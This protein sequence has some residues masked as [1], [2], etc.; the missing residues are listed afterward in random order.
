[1]SREIRFRAWTN[2]KKMIYDVVPFQWDYCLSRM[3]S[4][5]INNNGSGILGSG[6]TE[7]DFEV[8]GYSIVEG[9]LMQFTGLKD[10]NG[11]EIYEGDILKYKYYKDYGQSGELVDMPNILV[12]W[13]ESKARFDPLSYWTDYDE[14][15][16]TCEVIGNIH[17]DKHLIS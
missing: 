13:V 17:Q 6:G 9:D 16:K 14:Q 3:V 1:M 4:K 11:K 8:H 2:D 12:K 7:A 10:R 15:L 5:C